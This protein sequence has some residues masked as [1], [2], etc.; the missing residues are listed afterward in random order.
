M[1]LCK[2]SA[3]SFESLDF[4]PWKTQILDQYSPLSPTVLFIL[5]LIDLGTLIPSYHFSFLDFVWAPSRPEGPCNFVVLPESSFPPEVFTHPS[6]WNTM[7][8]VPSTQVICKHCPFI[9]L[10]L[11]NGHWHLTSWGSCEKAS[12]T[13]GAAGIIC[14]DSQTWDTL[15]DFW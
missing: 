6:L 8:S 2:W 9:P 7:A 10:C 12:W 4:F 13:L 15:L 1:T 3:S 11:R 14:L 5:D